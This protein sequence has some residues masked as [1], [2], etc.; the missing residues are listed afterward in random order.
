LARNDGIGSSPASYT[1]HNIPDS[2]SS[3]CS[4]NSSLTT[5]VRRGTMKIIVEAQRIDIAKIA[6]VSGSVLV[7]WPPR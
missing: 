3:A 2:S 6:A 4:I 1:S 7:E 5:T